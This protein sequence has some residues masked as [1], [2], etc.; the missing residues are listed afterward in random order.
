MCIFNGYIVGPLVYVLCTN[1]FKLCVILV[2]L[3]SIILGVA[4]HIFF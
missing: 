3:Y 4:T 1:N 2:E